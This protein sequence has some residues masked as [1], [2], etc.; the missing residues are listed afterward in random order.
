M[1]DVSCCY[2]GKSQF[3]VREV[4]NRNVNALNTMAEIK[5]LL[6]DIEQKIKVVKI[7]VPRYKKKFICYFVVQFFYYFVV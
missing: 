2:Q 1:Y 6:K 7:A 4:S 3:A 5:K